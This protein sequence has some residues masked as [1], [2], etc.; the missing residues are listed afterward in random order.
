M[1]Q[2][3]VQIQQIQQGYALTHYQQISLIMIRFLKSPDLVRD[4]IGH[5]RQKE[6][7]SAQQEHLDMRKDKFYLNTGVPY[8]FPVPITTHLWLVSRDIQL[9]IKCMIDGFL[10]MMTEREVNI[11]DQ[12]VHFSE[13]EDIR[14]NEKIQLLNRLYHLKKKVDTEYKDIDIRFSL[15]GHIKS[16]NGLLG[17]SDYGGIYLDNI[18]EHKETK[19][20]EIIV[21]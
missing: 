10:Y 19:D 13:K 17:D 6:F 1:S 2:G 12:L 5:L 15:N 16:L 20:M 9:D 8:S 11:N 3:C 4:F 14:L 7:F 21:L 18:S